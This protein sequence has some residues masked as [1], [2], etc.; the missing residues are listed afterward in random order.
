MCIAIEFFKNEFKDSELK[1]HKICLDAD[2]ARVT[3]MDKKAILPVRSFGGNEFLEWGNNGT[4]HCKKEMIVKGAWAH[5]RPELVEIIANRAL[6]H[7]IWFQVKEGIQGVTVKINGHKK[8]FIL[9]EP[10]THYFKTMTGADRMPVL[11][12]QLI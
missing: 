3:L 9:T 7:G 5:M 11:I 10:A 2:F 4:F 8:C 12:R 1:A 6:T